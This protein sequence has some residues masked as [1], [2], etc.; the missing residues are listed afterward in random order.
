M[1]L[2]VWLATLE[3]GV[4]ATIA[5]VA[6]GLLTPTGRDMGVTGESPLQYLESR[7]HPWV[8]FGI[9]PLFALANAGVPFSIGRMTHAVVPAVIT[10][11]V[12]GK[13]VGI[14]LF[15]FLTVVLI[16]R[17]LP[18]GITWPTLAGAGCLGGIGFTMALFISGL[19]L[20]ADALDA[21]KVG[22]LFGSLIAAVLGMALLSFAG[23]PEA[24]KPKPRRA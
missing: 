24:D 13:P 11:L 10:G 20:E 7:L 19:A 22:I 8:S 18:S 3:S 21:A 17:R 6:L 4:H 16:T 23:H 9:M 14:M 2:V 5:G 15:S 1:G 12:I